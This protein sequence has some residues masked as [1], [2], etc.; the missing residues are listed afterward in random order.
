MAKTGLTEMLGR[1]KLIH[2]ILAAALLFVLIQVGFL[3]SMFA[4]NGVPGGVPCT[5]STGGAI[6][7]YKSDGVTVTPCPTPNCVGGFNLSAREDVEDCNTLSEPA[8]SSCKLT[9]TWYNFQGNLATVKCVDM[10]VDVT[11]DLATQLNVPT[12]WHQPVTGTQKGSLEVSPYCILEYDQVS[13]WVKANPLVWAKENPW[14][15][16]GVFLVLLLVIVAL[17][18]KPGTL[19]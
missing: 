19:L 17:L 14:L 4:I 15:A 2:V 9:D 11:E 1:I 7:C 6:V 16:I 12:G 13:D 10:D 18:S 8:K 5:V 3:P